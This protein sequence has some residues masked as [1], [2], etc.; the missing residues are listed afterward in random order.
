MSSLLCKYWTEPV[1]LSE[2]SAKNKL[3]ILV[4]PEPIE[5]PEFALPSTNNSSPLPLGVT[6]LEEVEILAKPVTATP[7]D[8]VSNFLELS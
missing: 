5:I 4:L 8:V 1:L 7:V 2:L 3:P 6:P